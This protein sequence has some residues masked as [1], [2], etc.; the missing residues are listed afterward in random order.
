[1]S[2]AGSSQAAGP[3][4]HPFSE[5]GQL[6]AGY[7]LDR[8]LQSAIDGGDPALADRAVN[9]QF[10]QA[11]ITQLLAE[12]SGDNPGE[13]KT[14]DSMLHPMV[15]GER[16]MLN[17][18]EQ[19]GKVR[20]AAQ[21]AGLP[22]LREFWKEVVEE[23]SALNKDRIQKWKPNMK[24]EE[25]QAL[26]AQMQPYQVDPNKVAAMRQ[27]AV[28]I[29]AA[30]KQVDPNS[31][32]WTHPDFKD[33]A[34][35]LNREAGGAGAGY[36][37]SGPQEM[38]PGLVGGATMLGAEQIID[39]GLNAVY[40]MWDLGAKALYNMGITDSI[41]G[42]PTNYVRGPD[43]QIMT[44]GARPNPGLVETMA[45]LTAFAT[46]KDAL[47]MIADLNQARDME[48]LQRSGWSQIVYGTA[49]VAGMFVGFKP[50]AEAMHAGGQA[51]RNVM[52][53]G[54]GYMGASV[55]ERTEKIMSTL[56]FG[57]GAAGAN[58]VFMATAY[59][60]MDDYGDQFL[61]GAV[62]A[63]VVLAFGY[64]GNKLG[65]WLETKA[66]MPPF[67]ADKVAGAF[68]GLG[69]ATLET[70]QTGALWEFMR[71]PNESTLN[72]FLTNM[73]GFALMKGRAQSP[74]EVAMGKSGEAEVVRQMARAE[75][76][77][78]VAEGSEQHVKRMKEMDLSAREQEAITELGMAFRG[79]KHAQVKGDL[80][81]AEQFRDLER[82]AEKEL[83]IAERGTESKVEIEMRKL[84]E[85]FA[86]TPE[87]VKPSER[88]EEVEMSASRGFDAEGRRV[89]GPESMRIAATRQ[90]ETTEA[91]SVSLEQV[92]RQ[93]SGKHGSPGVQLPFLKWRPG[94][95]PGDQ[96][97]IAF[98]SG[99]IGHRGV[100]GLYRVLDN[101][102]RIKGGRDLIVAVHEWAHGMMRSTLARGKRG[103][104]MISEAE[105]WMNDLGLQAKLE[106]E[107]MLRNYPEADKL[108]EGQF[109][110][111][112]WAELFARDLLSDAK[113]DVEAPTLAKWMRSWLAKPENKSLRDQYIANRDVIW[114]WFQQG[115]RKRVRRSSGRPWDPSDVKRIKKE[116]KQHE[117]QER[118]GRL[119]RWRKALFDDMADIKRSRD[120]WLSAVGRNASEF[121]ITSDPA[122]M[123]D[124]TRGTAATIAYKFFFEGTY[125]IAGTKTGRALMETFREAMDTVGLHNLIDYVF[126]VRNLQILKGKYRWETN[127]QGQRVRKMVRKPGEA[128]LAQADYIHTIKEL[129]ADAPVLKRLG[130]QLK[131]WTDALVDY[132]Q[133]G[134][135]F[136]PAEAQAVKDAY[137]FYVPFMRAIEGPVGAPQ[138]RGPAER[139]SGVHRIEGSTFEVVDPLKTIQD[140]ATGMIQKGLQART[141]KALY[142]FARTSEAGGFAHVVDKTTIPKRM[143]VD[144]ALDQLRRKIGPE[145]E[146]Q[147]LLDALAD[148]PEI[149]EGTLTLFAQK[150]FPFGE[151]SVI[152]V[153]VNLQEWELRAVDPISRKLMQKDNGK[154][155]WLEVDSQAY[156]T[157]M[158]LEAVK[159]L[160]KWMT[161]PSKIVRLFATEL[162]PAFTLANTIRDIMMKPVF[163]ERGF[164]R[165]LGFVGGAMDYLAGAIEIF[166]RG[167]AAVLFDALAGSI[168]TF[169]HQGMSR[170]V[171]REIGARTFAA[172]Q[173]DRLHTTLDWVTKKLNAPEKFIR[174]KE[175]K[176]ALREAREAGKPEQ[177]ARLE[178]L[179]AARE[180]TVNF[181]KGGA[182]AR[183]FNQIIPYLKAG[184]LG[185]EKMVKSLSTTRGVMQA[186]A[187]I[188]LPSMLLW[189]LYK[190]DAW[191]QDL[192]EW[193]R[194]GYWNISF[195]GGE[196]IISLPKPFE[197]GVL[198]G[199]LPEFVMDKTSGRGFRDEFGGMAQEIM[200][201][202]VRSIEALIPQFVKPAYEVM[203]GR[204]AFR[205]EPL[206]NET[207]ARKAPEEQVYY[208]TTETAQTLF[209]W[210]G[211][212]L[213][214][215]D[216]PIEMEQILATYTAG[217]TT[218]LFRTVE[219]LAGIKDYDYMSFNPFSR[220]TKQ[221]THGQSK[222]EKV[223]RDTLK[224]LTARKK[225]LNAEERQ[226]YAR[227]GPAVRRMN[228]IRSD[229]RSGRLS[230]AEALQRIYE[231][232]VQGLGEAPVK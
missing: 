66:E 72:V 136:S 9:E 109:A 104:E 39:P 11:A 103:T 165:N 188:T 12:I 144:E 154:T 114:R 51:A 34:M 174:V 176:D 101:V 217:A 139:G 133:Q 105:K 108:S 205:G 57:M 87:E 73:A 135:A 137:A 134:G 107:F 20:Q 123:I 75:F 118:G 146:G 113:L 167:E 95:K 62:M 229:L 216:N 80:K 81:A 194:R 96:V 24:P 19:D 175:F 189:W 155:V 193:R 7:S 16:L 68:E 106:G 224:D 138:G 50:A 112:V 44:N 71:N 92:F 162:N 173:W 38:S 127:K 22:Q 117:K 85:E 33:M 170:E 232:G 18:I 37:V 228:A 74:G 153:P 195:N 213:P 128:T 26:L 116:Q 220:F 125:D 28:S 42:P 131:D 181:A 203:T 201:P 215:I 122:R 207:L 55:S 182:S 197:L 89:G 79:R 102:A 45:M 30:I 129:A 142:K 23:Y 159:Q 192:P 179:E 83:D 110:A 49:Q 226:L 202:Y 178:A 150:A 184:M 227:L 124:A 151:R 115:S 54:L 70:A 99:R 1:M 2:S 43:G 230:H 210:F 164:S 14:G 218:G 91:E 40:G 97:R 185:W 171:F 52:Q 196:D 100:E 58:G 121:E 157:L 199:S 61:H 17:W 98:R 177:V 35:W 206:L 15:V 120:R 211:D 69:F 119:H 111:E 231:A 3:G 47:D 212:K 214:W 222:T 172:R 32:F 158:G 84:S 13:P 6:Q 36:F 161:V 5:L 180:V 169:M 88:V 143:R 132:V 187:N 186:V 140:V 90:M 221:Q 67:L 10:N 141:M 25:E 31:S 163:S 156:V 148:I 130:K 64:G 48:E 168:S 166:K 219:D 29:D 76:A 204:S 46:E 94:R 145:H 53:K 191:Y 27:L 78:K 209:R 8:S 65:K 190:D 93:L 149:S 4:T 152:A 208:S 147:E 198:F 56:A 225:S 21:D 82:A 160:P 126:S 63:P 86:R 41:P 223:A 200:L 77:E 60:R 183:V 59:G